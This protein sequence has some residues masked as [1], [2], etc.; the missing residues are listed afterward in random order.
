MISWFARNHVAAN[1]LMVSIFIA[2]FLSL[3]R[4]IPLEVFPSVEANV[5]NVA[6]A[7]RGAT[8]EDIE[9]GVTIRVEE[10]VQD[11]EGIERLTSRSMEGVSLVTVEVDDGYDPREMLSDVKSRVDAIST[12]PGEAERPVISLAQHK[13]GVITVAVAGDFSERE[14]R[15]FGEQVRDDLLRLPEITQAEL[16]A[17]RDYEINITIPQD[18]LRNYQLTL[19]DIAAAIRDHSLDFSAGN[20]RAEGGDV[21]IRSKGQAYRRDEFE[22]IVV[23]TNAD[24][25]ILR[26]GDIAD[27]N[28][29]FTEDAVITRFNGQPASLI[30]VFRIGDQSAIEVAAAVRNYID[31]RRGS[32]PVGLQL[33]YWD[34]DSVVVKNR[35]NTLVRN[36]M[37]GGILV[38]ALLTLFLRPAI[39]FWVFWGI[40]ISF[41]GA[42]I[43]M[44]LFG[45]SL[46]ILSLFG[47]ILVLGIVVDD[48]IVTGE[49]VYTH[50]RT[51]E[52]GLE[53]AIRGTKEVA[54]PVTFGVLT[55]IVAFM[56]FAF[57]EGRR[58]ALFGQMA[59]VVIPVLLF[60]LV[61]SKLILPAHLKHIRLDNGGGR[62]QGLKQW[63]QRFASGFEDFVV[64][65]YRPLL[66][67][68]IQHRYS[69]L[70]L[71]FG[72]LLIILSLIT[73][74]WT[75]FIF[76]PR[77]E[78]ETATA[79]LAFPT[80]TPFEVTDRYIKH[81]ADMAREL[82]QKYQD[83]VLNKP[84]ITNILAASG[85]AGRTSGSH[86]GRVRFET[87][88][89]EQ[90][91]STVSIS[92]L[93]RE[94]R[95]MI[96]VIPGAESLTFRAEFG[97]PHDPIDLQFRG[98]SLQT[99]GEVANKAKQRLRTYPSVFDVSDS[100]SDGKEE[101][102]VEL[103]RQ[104]H[105]LGL[106]RRDVIIQVG[107]AFKGFEAQRVQRGRDDVRV[108]VRFPISERRSVSDLENMLITLP[109]GGQAPLSH[110]AR[111]L[112]GR[113]PAAIDR[114]DQYRTV[115]VT[116]DI[117]KQATNMTV[118]MADLTAYLDELLLQY[119]GV[120]YALEGEVKEQQESLTSI[121]VGV[122]VALFVIYCLLA[123]PFRSYLQPLVVMSVIPFG[124]IGAVIGHWL[125]G[126]SLSIMSVLG[127][128]ALVGVVVNDSLVMVDFINKH[129]RRNEGEQ[130]EDSAALHDAILN[131]GVA[132]FRPIMLTSLTTFFGLLPM[133]FERSTQAQFL[134][135]MAISVGCGIIFA[136]LITLL[137]VPVNYRIMED[138]KAF[139]R[140][141]L[142]SRKAHHHLPAG[143]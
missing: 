116:A 4:N 22:S 92:D 78:S 48:A 11:L 84:L 10:A 3:N 73:S 45:I 62:L 15:E 119:P 106:T 36:A 19:A 20:V 24:G 52:N 28:D 43:F 51:S 85:E 9:Q 81:M 118:L 69:T 114:I 56:P 133:L 99:L 94:W 18:R 74:G 138:G 49:N 95:E 17:V 103:T 7:L 8:P 44:P 136:T 100:L 50:L 32:L 105:A 2:G 37:Q 107:R 38:L 128:M 132:R 80:G 61:E 53:A 86:T 41:M 137:L 126:V 139:V 102:Q 88:A 130:E 122:L 16:S 97:R 77:V 90:R 135:P 6:V 26:L 127:I 64:G 71:F 35:L 89:A 5:V 60:S 91:S 120:D 110:V 75:R 143:S 68:C 30:D 58:G 87:I 96:G 33:D 65:Y 31:K 13:F 111:L 59:L 129:R 55:T 66:A 34:D 93:V 124:A 115:D 141:K 98:S 42:F 101:L 113:G 112:P 82:Q 54:I 29:G 104:G 140:R 125:L 108:L 1:L 83:P 121:L 72:V 47:F 40:P 21:L 39:A 109:S 46:N 131:A 23:K 117:N 134:M 142:R 57:V 27:V 70:I 123:I 67:R 25:T 14:I 63:Q 12:L 76:F 79:T